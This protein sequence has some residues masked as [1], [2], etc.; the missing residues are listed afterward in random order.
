MQFMVI[1]I[2]ALANPLTKLQRNVALI[3]QVFSFEE[4][5]AEPNRLVIVI[6]LRLEIFNLA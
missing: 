3:N 5:A 6:A 2:G 1:V 4:D